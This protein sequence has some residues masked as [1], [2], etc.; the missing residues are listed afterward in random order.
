MLVFVIP[1]LPLRLQ[2]EPRQA[3]WKLCKQS[4]LEQKYGNWRA[5]IV[6]VDPL[7]EELP[8][9][10]FINLEGDDLQKPLKLKIALEFIN[11]NFGMKPK[12][13]ARLDC[14]D[15]ISPSLMKLYNDQ[16]SDYDVMYDRFHICIDI[17]SLMMSYRQASW[18]PNTAIMKY[19][20]AIERFG[21]HEALF[22]EDHAKVWNTY[23]EGKLCVTTE[24]S[25]PIYYRILSPF[26][27]TSGYLN[28]VSDVVKY[29]K[30]IDGYGPWINISKEFYY[31]E[32]LHAIQKGISWTKSYLRPPRVFNY[33]KHLFNIMV[34]RK[35]A[36]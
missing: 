30:Y 29:R 11:E 35:V 12:H 7:R 6:G 8:H 36:A 33:V 15:I 27:I 9:P 31:Y 26:S 1:L 24:R 4:L 16:H 2:N 3:L 10:A 20:H 22:L 32:Q 28:G 34:G 17:L 18:I 5:I 14:D 25:E 19:E 21:E 23:F 13:L